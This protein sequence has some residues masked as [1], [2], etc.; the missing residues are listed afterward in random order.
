MSTSLP[1]VERVLQWAVAQRYLPA[2]AAVIQY[3]EYTGREFR[4]NQTNDDLRGVWITRRE[5][6]ELKGVSPCACS[7]T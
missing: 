3:G 4:I 5:A 2:A 1:D 6:N 7:K